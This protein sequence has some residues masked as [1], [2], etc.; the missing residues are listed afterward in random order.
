M[1]GLE[2][3]ATL[4]LYSWPMLEIQ[5]GQGYWKFEGRVTPGLNPLSCS[6]GWTGC[7]TTYSPCTVMTQLRNCMKQSRSSWLMW[8][9]PR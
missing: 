8:G 6:P 1:A 3:P 5:G 4:G 9:N 2:S 7:A